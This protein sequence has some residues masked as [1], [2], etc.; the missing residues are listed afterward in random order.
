M[1][2]ALAYGGFFGRTLDV[3]TD[4]GG[5]VISE[6]ELVGMARREK[7]KC[8]WFDAANACGLGGAA[9]SFAGLA[10]YSSEGEGE[11]R[12]GVPSF[13]LL[14]FVLKRCASAR[15]A[16]RLLREVIITD[17]GFSKE[18]PPTPLH[19]IFADSGACIVFEQ[20]ASGARVYDNAYGA[21]T[22]APEFPLH[23]RN[24]KSGRVPTDLSSESRFMRIVNAKRPFCGA[25]G[26]FDIM[27]SVFV[28]RGRGSSAEMRTAYTSCIDL[29]KGEYYLKTDGVVRMAGK[30]GKAA[31]PCRRTMS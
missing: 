18:L 14:P 31:E 19:W 16:E 20:T 26:F 25:Y 1:C 21:L 28:E 22:N 7:D 9:L 17:E 11:S 2:T 29:E 5:E 15:E 10:V 8:L 3:E 6:G 12:R 4:W 27:S 30:I 23:L 24:A 13:E